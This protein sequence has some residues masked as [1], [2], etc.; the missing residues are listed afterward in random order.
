MFQ[1]QRF[2]QLHY[3]VTQLFEIRSLVSHRNTIQ[4]YLVD[5]LMPPGNLFLSFYCHFYGLYH[6]K[7]LALL[8]ENFIPCEKRSI[9]MQSLL[10]WRSQMKYKNILIDE[11]QGGKRISQEYLHGI[12]SSA[13]L[14]RP[15]L[16]F[17]SFVSLLRLHFL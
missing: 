5:T 4:H 1:I 10:F 9:Q 2:R 12:R 15:C 16:G 14:L 6:L 13:S 3:T 11:F 8:Q 7:E 17:F